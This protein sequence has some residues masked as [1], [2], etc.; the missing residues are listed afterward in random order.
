MMT[1]AD[2]AAVLERLCVNTCVHSVSSLTLLTL[3][4]LKGSHELW[5]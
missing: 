4:D 1:A 2:T 5:V 3:H